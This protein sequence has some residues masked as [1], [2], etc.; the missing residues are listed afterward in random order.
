[1]LLIVGAWSK[2]CFKSTNRG[3]KMSRKRVDSGRIE[4]VLA[5]VVLLAVIGLFV[6]FQP[7]EKDVAPEPIRIETPAVS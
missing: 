4:T 7:V 3:G 1:M 6:R 2:D 5:A